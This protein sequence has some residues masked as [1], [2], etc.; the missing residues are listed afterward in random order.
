M[1]GDTVEHP[2]LSPEHLAVALM[3]QG[4]HRSE[5]VDIAAEVMQPLRCLDMGRQ[6]DRLRAQRLKHRRLVTAL[7]AV[8][9]NACVQFNAQ[10][11]PNA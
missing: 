4:A 9:E 11:D 1:S 3:A 10:G 8:W 2:L 6:L 7:D 5:A